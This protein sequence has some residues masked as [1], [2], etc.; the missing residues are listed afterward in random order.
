M[1]TLLAFLLL[2]AILISAATMGGAHNPF[3]SKPE[4]QH[5]APAPP[6][7]SEFFVKIIFWQHQLRQKMSELVRETK[8]TSSPKPLLLLLGVAFVYGMVHSAGPGHGKAFALTYILTQQPRL[9]QGVIFG[10]LIALFHGASGILLVLII[11]VLLEKSITG[12]M[13]G[14][15][16]ITQLISFGLIT[17]LGLTLFIH[18]AYRWIKS[19][20]ENQ[21]LPNKK[22]RFANPL[23]SSLA[24]GIIP[25]PVVVMV[26]LFA[27]SMD[28][29]GLGIILGLTIS[30]G[31]AL[32][33]TGVVLAGLSGKAAFLSMASKQ[34]KF[35]PV[36]EHVF[37]LMAA[38]AVTTLGLVFFLANY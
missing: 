26:M 2:I 22:K 33:I 15:S 21:T 9:S 5:R 18:K 35:F 23:F 36:F 37:E 28:M 34:K 8:A 27:L 10:N 16:R 12:T 14:V 4:E 1:K 19:K 30:I 29:M 11:R 24:V 31:M 25:C 38:L 3:T 6:V 17:C 20:K 7:K 13:A 32:T